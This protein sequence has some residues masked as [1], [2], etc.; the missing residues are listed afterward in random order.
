[1]AMSWEPQ[2]QRLQ[3]QTQSKAELLFAE[4]TAGML[5]FLSQAGTPRLQRTSDDTSC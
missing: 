5:E 2:L 4:R 1:M 3:Q